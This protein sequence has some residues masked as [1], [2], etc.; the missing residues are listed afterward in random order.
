[1]QVATTAF[2]TDAVSGASGGLVPIS[3]ATISTAVAA[4]DIALTGYSSF[5]CVIEGLTVATDGATL[6]A[7]FSTDG[8][9]TFDSGA[10]D[11]NG[12]S[13]SD[14]TSGA[15]GTQLD[16][17][18]LGIGNATDEEVHAH[19]NISGVGASKK[20]RVFTVGAHS[21]DS[22]QERGVHLYGR[23]NNAGADAIRFFASAGNLTAGTFRL[24]GMTEV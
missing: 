5:I 20:A 7:R 4:V 1:M 18:G 19:F 9:S 8:G 24:Y 6:Y 3:T 2:V 14:T 11:Y 10:T 15:D 21:N 13:F 12:A 23:H 17:T 16:V 22:S